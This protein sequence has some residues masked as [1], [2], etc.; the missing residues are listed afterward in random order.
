MDCLNTLRHEKKRQLLNH[1]SF[2]TLR[3]FIVYPSTAKKDIIRW[4]S[5]NYSNKRPRAILDKLHSYQKSNQETRSKITICVDRTEIEISDSEDDKKL[6]KNERI[7]STTPR[8]Y[9]PPSLIEPSL[10]RDPETADMTPERDRMTRFTRDM[11]ERDDI[12][13]IDG[14]SASQSL[15]D[16]LQQKESSPEEDIQEG[17]VAEA[18][19]LQLETQEANVIK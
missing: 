11:S 9:P 16:V 8:F 5:K 18:A 17:I 2:R 4:D 7:P 13:A 10:K 14:V 1:V 12:N 15:Q 19:L 6:V 3:V